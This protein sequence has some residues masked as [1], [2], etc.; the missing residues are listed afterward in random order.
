MML[1]T[2]SPNQASLGGRKSGL[3]GTPD[4]PEARHHRSGN[5]R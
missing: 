3:T 5:A 1:S 2:E 4:S